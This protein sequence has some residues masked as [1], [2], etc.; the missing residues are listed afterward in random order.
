MVKQRP[1]Y[2]TQKDRTGRSRYGV[3]IEVLCLVAV[4]PV[5]L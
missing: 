2:L 1:W 4:G 3:S 5:R